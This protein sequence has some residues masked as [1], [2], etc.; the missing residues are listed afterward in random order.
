[1]EAAFINVKKEYVNI[2]KYQLFLSFLKN[3]AIF[4]LDP[5]F[6]YFSSQF[7]FSIATFGPFSGQSRSNLGQ[8][9]KIF[10]QSCGGHYYFNRVHLTILS[11]GRQ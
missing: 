3:T 10:A 1:M 8:N 7:L 4:I 5:Y 2:L 6:L 11:R 9:W